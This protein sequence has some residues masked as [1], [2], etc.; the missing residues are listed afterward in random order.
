MGIL[1]ML[2]T[3]VNAF[4]LVHICSVLFNHKYSRQ[5]IKST[6]HIQRSQETLLLTWI[7]FD[8]MMDK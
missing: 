2:N 5:R 6:A 4:G 3:S 1:L 7:N 8:P